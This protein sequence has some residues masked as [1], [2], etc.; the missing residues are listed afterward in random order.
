MDARLLKLCQKSTGSSFVYSSSS[1]PVL[2]AISFLSSF[3]PL[4]S[5]NFMR[6]NSSSDRQKKQQKSR[7]SKGPKSLTKNQ[8]QTYSVILLIVE[9]DLGGGFGYSGSFFKLGYFVLESLIFSVL[10]LIFSDFR[11]QFVYSKRPRCVNVRAWRWK[12][13]TLFFP[14]LVLFCQ[15]QRCFFDYTLGPWRADQAAV[16]QIL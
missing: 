10:F 6:L 14:I 1:W 12:F 8:K 5:F 7:Q 16:L 9:C 13:S 15:H 4:S 2:S 3:L 11:H